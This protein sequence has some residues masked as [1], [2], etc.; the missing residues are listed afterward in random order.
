MCFADEFSDETVGIRSVADSVGAAKK[1]LETDVGNALTQVAQALPG[2]FVQEAH[3]SVKRCAAPHLEAEKIGQAMRDGG[4]SS[5]QVEC[6]NAGSHQGLMSVAERWFGGERGHLF[7]C[8]G[9]TV[10]APQP[11]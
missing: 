10:F 2:I 9:G 3:R 7:S 4:C 8:P 11:F 6:G 5:E 1:H